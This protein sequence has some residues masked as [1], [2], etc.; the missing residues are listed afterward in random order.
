MR[1][2]FSSTPVV[3]HQWFCYLEQWASLLIGIVCLGVS[4][5]VALHGH[6]AF[7]SGQRSSFAK[8]ARAILGWSL[9]IAN[10]LLGF[11]LLR[12]AFYK[13][14]EKKADTRPASSGPGQIRSN[15]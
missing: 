2:R 6:G 3:S 10:A 8:D 13:P 15:P 11:I 14:V 5:W 7:S 1:G 9:T 4:L 12:F